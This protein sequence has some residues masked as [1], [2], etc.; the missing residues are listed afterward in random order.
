MSSTDSAIGEPYAVAASVG[1]ERRGYVVPD[2]VH[3]GTSGEERP[4]GSPVVHWEVMGKDADAL[5]KFYAS[6]FDWNFEIDNPMGYGMV[7]PDQNR[8]A[9]ERGI[10]GGIGSMPAGDASRA[11]RRSTSESPTSSARCNRR[12]NSA[13]AA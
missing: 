12:S 11:T 5:R 10:G 9:E 4:M 7:A 6:M 13:A 8:S 3:H 2:P 1:N